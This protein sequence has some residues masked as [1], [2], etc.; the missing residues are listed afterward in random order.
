MQCTDCPS[1]ALYA[2]ALVVTR[3]LNTSLA[4]YSGSSAHNMTH[5]CRVLSSGPAIAR[6]YE[7]AAYRLQEVLDSRVQFLLCPVQFSR[8]HVPY[9]MRA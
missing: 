6:L 4:E 1:W 8:L 7:S 5:G 9:R 3:L 2:P